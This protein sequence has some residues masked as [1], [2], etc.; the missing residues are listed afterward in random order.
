MAFIPG[1]YLNGIHTVDFLIWRFPNQC[2]IPHGEC[3]NGIHTVDLAYSAE[4]AIKPFIVSF[5]V[6]SGAVRK[7]HLPS[8]ELTFSKSLFWRILKTK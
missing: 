5:L 3:L 1:E 2:R 4:F 7:P 6:G 8:G